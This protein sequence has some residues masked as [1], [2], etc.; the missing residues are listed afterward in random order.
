MTDKSIFINAHLRCKSDKISEFEKLLKGMLIPSR[1]EK[2]CVA[3][4]F[5]QSKENPCHFVFI[6]E[7]ANSDAFDNHLKSKH[8]TDYASNV[9]ELLD[10]EKEVYFLSVDKK[11]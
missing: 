1:S 2:G 7:W 10:G 11:I 5:F 6:E 9:G 8:Y 3:Y 4:N